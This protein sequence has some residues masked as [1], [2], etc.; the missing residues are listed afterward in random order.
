MGLLQILLDGLAS[1]LGAVGG[2]VEGLNP[3]PFAGA[4]FEFG[5]D[6]SLA[7]GILSEFVDVAF[8][9]GA[10]M[11]WATGLGVCWLVMTCWRWVKA[12]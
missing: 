5:S 2:F 9:V 11:A 4:G 8:C 3:C 6:F 1:F 12:Q 7:F 10:V